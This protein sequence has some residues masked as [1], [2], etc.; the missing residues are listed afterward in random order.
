[1]SYIYSP[2]KSWCHLYNFGELRAYNAFL[3][4]NHLDVH[5]IIVMVVPPD[6][7]YK[8]YDID[9]LVNIQTKRLQNLP[10]ITILHELIE[11]LNLFIL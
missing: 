11:E 2:P 8:N 6:E 7:S 5:A 10:S 9:I 3:Q 1:M 4:M